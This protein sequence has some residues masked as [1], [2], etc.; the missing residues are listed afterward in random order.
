M[1]PPSKEAA[2][3]STLA[4]ERAIAALTR[5]AYETW[6]PRARLAVLDG[7]ALSAAGVE[8]T[9][10]DPSAVTHTQSWWD[11][12]LD[13]LVVYGVGLVFGWELLGAL[14]AV[15]GI[16]AVEAAEAVERE[17]LGGTVPRTTRVAVTT[18]AAEGL[19]PET[20]ATR[21]RRLVGAGLGLTTREVTLLDQRLAAMPT[22]RQL[23]ADH[24]ASVRNRMRGTPD[25]VFREITQ[26]LD[27]ALAAGEDVRRMRDRVSARLSYADGNWAGR[28]ELVARTET[29]GAMSYATEEAARYRSRV[30]GDTLRKAWV[31]TVDSRTRREHFALD[32]AVVPLDGKFQMGR[33]ELRRPGDS[34]APVEQTANCFTGEVPVSAEG[35]QRVFRSMYSGPLVELSTRGG[36]RLTG[37]PNHPV[38]TERGWVGL[39]QLHKG[40]RLVRAPRGEQLA[41]GDPDVER[42][43]PVLAEV[44]DA[45]QGVRAVERVD[46]VLVDFH[47]DR[48]D[49][50]VEVVAVDG[51]LRDRLDT[52]LAQQL[53]ELALAGRDVGES[54]FAGTRASGDLPVSAHATSHGLVGGA[55]EAPPLLRTGP[56]HPLHH[57]RG[58]A[59]N[60]H[61][62]VGEHLAD[63][64]P[65][66]SGAPGEGLLADARRVLADHLAGVE[67]RG[68]LAGETERR[69]LSTPPQRPGAQ[70]PVPDEAVA[71]TEG[72]GDLLRGL[73]GLVSFDEVEHVGTRVFSG[74]V[75][76]LQTESGVFLADSIVSRNCRCRLIIL[77]EDETLPG[78]ADR[79]TE[80]SST[81]ATVRNREGSQADEIARRAQDGTV[82][83][84]D[85][86][87]GQG[88]V[89][90]SIAHRFTEHV[91]AEAGLDPKEPAVATYRSFT[92]VLAVIGTPTDDRRMFAEDIDLRFRQFPLP[93][94]WQK[95][96]EAEHYNSFT[97]GV[98]EEAQVKGTQ[99]IGSG[100][101]LNTPE[102]DEAWQM[103]EHGV[104]APSVDLGDAEW[105][106]TNVDGVEITGEELEAVMWGEVE[107]KVYETV[108]SA[109][110]MGFT[111][112][113]TPAFGE[114]SITLAGDVER[115]AELVA[116]AVA[117]AAAHAPTVERAYAAELFSN[118]QLTGP[119]PLTYDAKTGRVYGHLACFG[120]CHIG[121]GDRCVMAPRTAASYAHFH[122]SP[123][124]LLEDGSRLPVGRLTVGTGH[125]GARLGARP[126]AE[127]Y[128]H[129]GTAW[130]LVRV[131]ED[132]HGIWFS[133]VVAP[134]A[135]EK[136]VQMGV[137]SALSGDWRTIAGNLE[138]V[139]ALSVNTPGFPILASGATD[140]HDRP[141]SLVASLGPRVER[142]PRAG[143]DTALLARLV[144]AEVRRQTRREEEAQAILASVD[145]RSADQRRARARALITTVEV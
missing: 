49:G 118:P 7:A 141:L 38:L 10:P 8:D 69:G 70:Q 21:S 63:R 41:G 121:I 91:L 18:A 77:G 87:D 50:E 31:A 9:S 96:T 85:S 104:T 12:L 137:S 73:P 47:G 100:Y 122:T 120:T 75:Y 48:P 93:V 13:H 131:G 27:T 36:R 57:R 72:V 28:A 86:D 58:P 135:E 46:G 129:T 32:G 99:V 139:A 2:L 98:L 101:F 45:A 23:Q 107:M 136:T 103:V 33:Y 51:E 109:V 14:G 22:I 54:P 114:T 79:Q 81:D 15:G 42:Q 25:A 71:D 83:A 119:T 88:S 76:T 127:H 40:D 80:R 126:A 30:L 56:R 64:V 55:G 140:A 39:G 113:A 67:A 34:S 5:S 106:I 102:A 144:A 105:K 92:A 53:G 115:G 19:N 117:H 29:C 84:R 132:A 52:A 145:R 35:A 143:V 110:L 94:M 125:A 24:L 111:L 1:W 66:D 3:V 43:P 6:L 20:L 90:A 130:A 61:P 95:Q 142:R 59:A 112:V 60:L 108:T 89:A 116:S 16:A 123:P 44:F 17:R 78:E 37:T 4:S 124:V 128:D 68:A 134:W 133:G 11:T 62:G 82:R 65:V 74:H 26:E 97:V 138:L